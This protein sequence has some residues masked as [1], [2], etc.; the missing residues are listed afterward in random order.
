MQMAIKAL[1]GITDGMVFL[2]G[3]DNDPAKTKYL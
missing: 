2:G 3:R 1:Q